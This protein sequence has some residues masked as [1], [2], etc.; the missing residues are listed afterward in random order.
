MRRVFALCLMLELV[1]SG[2]TPADPFAFAGHPSWSALTTGGSSIAGNASLGLTAIMRG[3]D[4]RNYLVYLNR[5]EVDVLGG[6]F[7]GLVRMVVGRRLK[8]EASDVLRGLR[9]RLESGEPV[10]PAPA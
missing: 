2:Q 1:P 8:A 7:G 6:F 5:S 9:N 3:S 4:G 10:L